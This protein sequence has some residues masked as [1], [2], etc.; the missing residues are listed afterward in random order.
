MSFALQLLTVLAVTA[1]V[2]LTVAGIVVTWNGGD[3]E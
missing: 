2:V 3:D 1:F